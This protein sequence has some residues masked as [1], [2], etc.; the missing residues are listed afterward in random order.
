MTIEK[1]SKPPYFL[2]S[3]FIFLPKEGWRQ[4]IKKAG[5]IAPAATIT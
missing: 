2:L 3:F 5:A 1:N 4:D